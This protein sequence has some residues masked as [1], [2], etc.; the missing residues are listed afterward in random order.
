MAEHQWLLV[1]TIE[2]GPTVVAHGEQPRNFV[3]LQKILRRNPHRE[4][5]TQ[6]VLEASSSAVGSALV[7][8]DGDRLIITEPVVMTDNTVHGVQVW[9]GPRHARR[10][11][12]PA[13]GAVVWDLTEGTAADTPQALL[14]RGMDPRVERT[15]GRSIAEDLTVSDPTP[16][17]NTVLALAINARE[18]QTYCS[19]W[20]V[21]TR[22]GTMI[23]VSFAARTIEEQWPDGTVHLIA[24][25][26][27]W[28]SRRRVE[29][30][31]SADL[32]SRIL[33]GTAE[34]GVHRALVDL[35]NWRLLKWIDPPSPVFDWRG[36][37]KGRP[38]VHPD[39]EP[40]LHS[41]TAEFA[42]GPAS[43]VLRMRARD[44][45]W[46][47]VHVTVY[48]IELDDNVHAGLISTRLPTPSEIAL[49]IHRSGATRCRR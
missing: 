25:A 29:S 26:M 36:Q 43:A 46:V 37:Q 47:H 8:R 42:D 34:R 18:G 2:S 49:H 5:L 7:S 11:Q 27:N 28:R 13:I 9:T 14:N 3:P 38:L 16:D 6:A 23:T 30:G 45:Q 20:D 39:D 21:R 41:M 15:H 24:R 35:S 4:Q 48:R 12:R 40:L 19:T 22:D 31:T 44:P 10:P 33:R 32:A 17:E 1:D